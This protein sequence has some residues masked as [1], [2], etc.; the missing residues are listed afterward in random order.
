MK[1]FSILNENSGFKIKILKLL[2]LV[3]L[4]KVNKEKV[5]IKWTYTKMEKDIYKLQHFTILFC[6]LTQ[7]RSRIELNSAI[8]SSLPN[9]RLI[10]KKCSH[11]CFIKV[12][13]VTA[14]NNKSTCKVI[15]L[16]KNL[17][18]FVRF[19]TTFIYDLESVN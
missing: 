17:L 10:D 19:D 11:E 7:Y 4:E 15:F 12:C 1:L 13:H 9:K 2:I 5:H 18:T 16:Y 3:A 8:K 6:D 14:G